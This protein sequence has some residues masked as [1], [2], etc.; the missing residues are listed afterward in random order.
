MQSLSTSMYSKRAFCDIASK[1]IFRSEKIFPTG[2][3]LERVLRPALL[4]V[5]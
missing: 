5:E 4:R 2:C 1:K 3:P